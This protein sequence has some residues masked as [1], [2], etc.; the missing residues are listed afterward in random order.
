MDEFITEAGWKALA[1]WASQTPRPK[2][3]DLIPGLSGINRQLLDHYRE[4][5]VAWKVGKA[6]AFQYGL[7]Q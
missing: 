7:P 3:P 4:Q 1:V 5:L 6:E 2:P